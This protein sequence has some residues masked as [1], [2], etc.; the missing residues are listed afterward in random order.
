MKVSKSFLNDYIDILDISFHEIAEKMVFLGNEYDDISEMSTATNLVIGY[1]T[2]TDAHPNA[3]TLK[4]C[5]VDIGDGKIYQIVCGAPNVEKG[6]KVIVAKVGAKMPGGLTISKSNIRGEESNGMICSLAELGLDSKFLNKEDVDGIHVLDNDAPV[7]QDALQYIG[8]DDEVIDFDLTPDRNDLLS[9]M[10]MA[11][12]VGAIYDLDVKY[13]QTD[14]KEIGDSIKDNFK[15]SVETSNCPLYFAR[16]VKDVKVGKTPTFIKNRLMASGIRSI[17]NVVDISNYVMLETGQPLHFFDADK[18]N[19]EIKVRMAESG[20][21]FVT[22]DGVERTLEQDDIVITDGKEIIALG[23]V[24]GGYNTEVT[25][26]TQNIIIESAIFNGKNIRNTSKRILRSEAST[27]FEKGVSYDR[28]LLALNRA[29]YLLNKYASGKVAHEYL[30]YDKI[31]RVETNIEVSLNKINKILGLSLTNAQVG[32]VFKKL[33][34]IYIENNNVFKVTVPPRRMDLKIPEDLIEEVGRIIGYDKVVGTLP[35]VPIKKGN[36]SSQMKFSKQIKQRLLSLGLNE[37]I[38]YSLISEEM[39]SK[40]N[41][42]QKKLVKLHDPLSVDRSIMRTNLITSLLNVYNYN[43]A[44]SI[45]DV[46]IFEIGSVYYFENDNYVEKLK[47]T[48][49]LSGMYLQNKW[50]QQN[51]KVDFYLAKG[52]I[53]NL[54]NYIGLEN[55][56][57]FVASN[58]LPDMHPGRTAK[59]IVGRDEVGFIG[60]IHPSIN[61]SEVYVF[62][63]D[64]EQLF[65]IKTRNIKFK[66]LNKYPSVNKDVAFIVNKEINSAQIEQIIKKVGGR[67]LVDIEVFDVYE[68][69]NIS[70]NQKSLA[71]SL[72]FQDSNKTLTDEEITPIFNKII[73]EVEQKLN[74]KLRDK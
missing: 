38:T 40:F 45:N 4:V 33:K 57:S 67:L 74:A 7:G 23:G 42:D 13:P 39:N 62:D 6:Q 19:S 58:T 26:Q 22:L 49:L 30:I 73:S 51:V 34:L 27:R 64:F 61:K 2:K 32:N 24:M 48:G 18:M 8:F 3:D 1:V 47:I 36:Y 9:I 46:N 53:E 43:N 15:L 69:I 65:N 16:L 37:V 5:Q 72:E 68:G 21:K 63:L 44:R 66:E 17:N 71:Y 60:Q 14:F 56:Y 11:Y 59:I 31:D 41:I 12:E 35:V 50:Q 54:L 10:G 25:E 29:C 70:N 52:V 55:R 20:E 28:S